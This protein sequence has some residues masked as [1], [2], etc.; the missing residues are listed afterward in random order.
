MRKLRLDLDTLAVDSFR[1]A[2]GSGVPGTVKGAE[3]EYEP[4]LTG[5]QPPEPL[6]TVYTCATYC[7]QATCGATC[8]TCWDPTCDSC[9]ATGCRTG[10][11]PECCG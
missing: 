1:T 10:V 11:S 3:N 7:G 9:Y 6:V 2:D 5:P 4:D 8:H